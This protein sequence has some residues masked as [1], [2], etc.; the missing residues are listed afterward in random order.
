M[1]RSEIPRRK[2]EGEIMKRVMSV[3]ALGA[4]AATLLTATA[5]TKVEDR[6]PDV[7]IEAPKVVEEKATTTS[8]TTATGSSTD[9]TGT[10]T[11]ATTVTTA[12]TASTK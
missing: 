3:L 12:T 2:K 9:P 7:K 5:C 11:T 10:M 8:T 1:Q 4:L 6:R